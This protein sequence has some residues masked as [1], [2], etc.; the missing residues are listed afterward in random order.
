MKGKNKL[1]MHLKTT[2]NFFAVLNIFLLKERYFIH[3]LN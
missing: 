3:W 2:I 1:V